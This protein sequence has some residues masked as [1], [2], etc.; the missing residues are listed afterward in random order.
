M[1]MADRIQSLRKGRGMS[2]EEL[3]ERIGVSRQAVS[4]WESEQS[5]PDLERVVQLSEL[6]EVSTDYLLKGEEPEKKG[7]KAERPVAIFLIISTVMNI[8]GN[9]SACVLWYEW[10][11]A[12]CILVGALFLIAGGMLYAMARFA[13]PVDRE[14]TPY[15]VWWRGNIWLVLFIPLAVVYNLLTVGLLAPYPLMS[16]VPGLLSWFWVIYI[17]AGTAVMYGMWKK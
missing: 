17:G 5:T 13:F 16:G 11:R 14:K 2:Q 6:F 4:K 7:G 9:L 1:N 8:M 3:A 10:Q 12:W 15:K